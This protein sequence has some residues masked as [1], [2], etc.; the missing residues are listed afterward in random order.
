MWS[1]AGKVAH[2][3]EWRHSLALS[4]SLVS[5]PGGELDCRINMHSVINNSIKRNLQ[6]LLNEKYCTIRL[7]SFSSEFVKSYLREAGEND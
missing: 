7:V 5:S 3:S 1:E 4:L 2:L 6:H